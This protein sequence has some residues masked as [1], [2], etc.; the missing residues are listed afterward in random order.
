VPS[1][2]T[3]IAFNADHLAL[4]LQDAFSRGYLSPEL[5]DHWMPQATTESPKPRR[6]CAGPAGHAP[7]RFLSVGQLGLG[8]PRPP[9][10]ANVS[11]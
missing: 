3:S 7:D 6:K 4:T 5:L 9:A 1:P 10:A 2:T 11:E 8:T